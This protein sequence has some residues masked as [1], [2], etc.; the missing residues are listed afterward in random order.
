MKG[1]RDYGFPAN[2]SLAWNAQS[3]AVNREVAGDEEGA[4]S[5]GRSM[6]FG[7]A[8]PSWNS[9]E[10]CSQ[11][12][13]GPRTSP[14]ARAGM[15]KCG[16]KQEP[17]VTDG[18]INVKFFYLGIAKKDIFKLDKNDKMKEWARG[19]IQVQ[20]WTSED[21][22]VEGPGSRVER[23]S[24]PCGSWQHPPTCRVL[25]CPHSLTP[26]P[27]L[28]DR[29]QSVTCF[30]PLKNH[31]SRGGSSQTCIFEEQPTLPVVSFL[32]S[33]LRMNDKKTRL[34]F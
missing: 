15:Q 9:V 22:K 12:T 1:T 30:P 33:W 20:L 34:I 21:Q 26:L 24:I 28:E 18:V 25:L 27:V 8:Q 16:L 17:L 3:W 11:R 6:V 2:K 32:S 10:C 14:L 4:F 13:V 29:P 19:K 5:Q 7:A 23:E 31:S